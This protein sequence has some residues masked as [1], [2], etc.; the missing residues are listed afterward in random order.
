MTW[1]G[2]LPRW[3]WALHLARLEENLNPGNQHIG[4]FKQALFSRELFDF[5]L[6]SCLKKKT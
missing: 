1:L 2:L 6:N 4:W 3:F 5:N